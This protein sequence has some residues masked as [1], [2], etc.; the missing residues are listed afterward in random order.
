MDW[1]EIM[2]MK[3]SVPADY[4][5]KQFNFDVEVISANCVARVWKIYAAQHRVHL[6]ALRRGLAMS[7]FINV[8]LLAVVMFTIGGR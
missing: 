6:T 5:A 3:H 8:I 2:L 7:I 4:A 1:F